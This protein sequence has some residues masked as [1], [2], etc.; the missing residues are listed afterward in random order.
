MHL[1]F[2][3]G[4]SRGVFAMARVARTLAKMAAVWLL[5]IWFLGAAFGAFAAIHYGT[6]VDSM[7][8]T[9]GNA[10]TEKVDAYIH[11]E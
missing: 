11:R 5:V 2:A 10:V 4:C 1:D 8:R 7:L 3:R 9:I 6:T